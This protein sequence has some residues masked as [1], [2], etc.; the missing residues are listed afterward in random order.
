ME[1]VFSLAAVQ[2]QP[3][4]DANALFQEFFRSPRPATGQ[5]LAW[6][7]LG[8]VIM[9][10]AYWIA[11]NIVA[12]GKGS[13]LNA[14]KLW[15]FYLVASV[16]VVV[17]AA[18]CIAIGA[19]QQSTALIFASVT[20]SMIL[21][22]AVVFGMPMKVYEIGLGRAVGF[23]LLVLLLSTAAQIGAARFMPAP[24]N[25]GAHATFVK[26]FAAL[27]A[28]ERKKVVE[29]MQGE[30]KKKGRAEAAKATDEAIAGDRTR[31]IPERHEAVQRIYRSLEARRLALKAGDQ[32]AIEAY[33]RDDARYQQL[34]RQLQADAAAR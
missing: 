20:V 11:S 4:P 27:P 19:L 30:R 7:G 8:Q 33:T 2:V 15:A 10:L 16:A 23:V 9:L 31:P 21:M 14:V 34:L 6:V 22:F 3:P 25:L 17:I 1:F 28:V 29:R 32:A 5:V 13:P 26:R 18:V 12:R 24:L